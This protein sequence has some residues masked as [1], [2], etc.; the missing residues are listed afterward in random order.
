MSALRATYRL[1]LHAGFG[2]AEVEK[3]LPYWQDLGISHLYL[4]PITAAL[5]GSTHFYDVVDPTR[6]SAE[7]G[8]EDGFR[9]M[10]QA[11]RRHD[12][13]IILDIVP[14]HMGIG[15][16]NPYWMEMLEHGEKSR[17]AEIFDV[18]WSR[19]HIHL[20]FLRTSLEEALA[21]GELKFKRSAGGGL[22]VSYFEHLLPLRLESAAEVRNGAASPTKELL[23]QQHW[24][25]ASWRSA[26]SDINYRRFFDVSMLV[27]VHT[28]TAH[29]FEL[30]HA[31]P[32]RLAGEGLIQGLRID[33]VDG[34]ALPARYCKDLRARVGSDVTLHV[35]KILAFDEAI[36]D[37]PVDGTTGYEMLNLINGLFITAEGYENLRAH[38]VGA[39]GVSRTVQERIAEA[40]RMVLERSFEPDLDRVLACAT[41][42]NG[43]LLPTEALRPAIVELIARLP[44]YRTYLTAAPPAAPEEALIAS[45]LDDVSLVPGVRAEAVTLLRR[46]LS[47]PADAVVT[48]FRIRLQQ[49]T[50]PVMAKGYEDTE[51][52]RFAVHLAANEVGSNIDWPYVTPGEFHAQM[53]V[54]LRGLKNLVPL[55]TH[56]T[57]RGADT[58]ARL[59]ALSEIA[60]A[61][62]AKTAR[63]SAMNH[64][65]R[66]DVA[67]EPAPAPADEAMIYQTLLGVWPGGA[68]RIKTA[69]RKSLR[70]A[71]LRSSWE[72]P[73]EAYEAAVM[74]FIEALLS[75][76]EA[77]GFRAEFEKEVGTVVDAGWHN[78]VQQTVLQLTV[79]GIA[80][81]YQGTELADFSLVDPDNRRPV[82][83]EERL[84]LM[85]N[86]EGVD[87]IAGREKYHLIRRLLHLRRDRPRLFTEGEYIPIP[88][89]GDA[90]CTI[91][92]MAFARRHG[93]DALIVVVETRGFAAMGDHRDLTLPREL[94]GEW[95]DVRSGQRFT[96]A[97]EVALSTLPKT[98]IIL[99]RA[100]GTGRA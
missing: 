63:W 8:G 100:K 19:G 92:G 83:W 44:I 91:S 6:V 25:L 12:L 38:A 69:V 48:A 18:D 41:K 23:E 66:R 27:A 94:A 35:E 43:G 64:G 97:G 79:P 31:L 54:R 9:R 73:N 26:A 86:E 53:T 58:R 32:I 76:D 14:N 55:A 74:D 37:W 70:E 65:L 88:L 7:L 60:E 75:A 95:T 1:Q 56:D 15:A 87:R 67:G 90:D 51:L 99:L 13:G 84:A 85:R 30:F 21:R 77:V 68:E 45:V 59:D 71:K 62:I 61:W 98:P 46:W 34:L 39:L 50:S 33:H 49:L 16:E 89:E 82:A 4:S 72:D 11:A 40:K 96:L 78:S 5:P 93:D 24:R 28:E 22:G 17:A 57:K 47:G 3:L 42:I 29:V 2:F 52:Y 20:P 10:A 36:P 80:D 81:I